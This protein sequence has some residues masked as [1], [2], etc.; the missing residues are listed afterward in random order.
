MKDKN[1]H[2]D[3]CT[4]IYEYKN[5]M[6]HHGTTEQ[7]VKYQV[8]SCCFFLHFGAAIFDDIVLIYSIF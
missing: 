1:H 3:V 5:I 8:K 6:T 7:Y 2:N 4:I